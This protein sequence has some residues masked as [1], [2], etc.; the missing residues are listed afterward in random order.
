MQQKKYGVQLVHYE[1]MGTMRLN[2]IED[3]KRLEYT[4]VSEAVKVKD[5]Y[6]AKNPRGLYR[7]VEYVP[8]FHELVVEALGVQTVSQQDHIDVPDF[9]PMLADRIFDEG[10]VA[11][12]VFGEN[13]HYRESVTKGHLLVL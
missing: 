3:G 12:A 11:A 10:E 5:H 9:K 6:A 2:V 8:T 7:V 13:P 4:D 1:G